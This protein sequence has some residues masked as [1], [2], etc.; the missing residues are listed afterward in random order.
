MAGGVGGGSSNLPP[1]RLA[2]T[3][4]Q[5]VR[6][7]SDWKSMR[8]ILQRRVAE[9]HVIRSVLDSKIT[10]TGPA[11]S[12]G[13]TAHGGRGCSVRVGRSRFAVRGANDPQTNYTRWWRELQAFSGPTSGIGLV[14]LG[15][16]SCSECVESVSS[17]ESEVLSKRCCTFGAVCSKSMKLCQLCGGLRCRASQKSLNLFKYLSPLRIGSLSYRKRPFRPV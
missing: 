1:T 2:P 11:A 17:S 8:H 9:T 14:L 13:M 5:R 16:A 6:G 15:T 3:F 12:A 10:S 7:R 4:E